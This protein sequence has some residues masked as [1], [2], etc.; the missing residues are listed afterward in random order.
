MK[1]L[2]ESEMEYIRTR[3]TYWQTKLGQLRWNI[4]LRFVPRIDTA[5]ADC[6]CRGQ[7]GIADIR[8]SKQF[9]DEWDNTDLDK[10]AFHEVSEIKYWI[11]R[12]FLAPDIADRIVHEWIRTD[13][14]TVFE[15]MK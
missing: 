8:F 2:S 4:Q 12:E 5:K 7:D 3:I 10:T 14:N 6:E 11:L 13:E 9:D 15:Y 1:R